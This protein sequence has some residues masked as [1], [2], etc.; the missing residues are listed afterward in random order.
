MDSLRCSVPVQTGCWPNPAQAA[1]IYALTE[2]EPKAE[3]GGGAGGRCRLRLLVANCLA[4]H[5]PFESFEVGSEQYGAWAG[6][7]GRVQALGMDVLRAGGKRWVRV[8]PWDW[9]LRGAYLVDEKGVMERW[10]EIILERRS[11]VEVDVVAVQEG[12]VRSLLEYA[13]LHR[14]K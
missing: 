12:C 1:H 7:F 2:D 6:L 11:E 10:E 4:A 5:N 9:E 13:H 8:Q 14:A 3:Y